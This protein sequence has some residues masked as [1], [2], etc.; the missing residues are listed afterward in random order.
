[1]YKHRFI[2]CVR[3]HSI[4]LKSNLL[5]FSVLCLLSIKQW[6]NTTAYL[7]CVK[8]FSLTV[9]K[10]LDH[11]MTLLIHKVTYFIIFFGMS[12]F[13]NTFSTTQEMYKFK[14]VLYFG[15]V[16]CNGSKRVLPILLGNWNQ[17]QKW[18][19]INFSSH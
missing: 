19:I 2:W 12:V 1:M 7:I 3:F 18:I 10:N 17:K 6:F 14:D 11:Q 13:Q 16:F 8:Y 15:F 4:W 9:K 5:A